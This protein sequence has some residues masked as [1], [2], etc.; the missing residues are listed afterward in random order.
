MTISMSSVMTM[1]KSQ[2]LVFHMCRYWMEGD[3]WKDKQLLLNEK[4]QVE[5]ISPD[6]EVY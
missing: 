3:V 1:L 2:K 4:E 5:M 6:N